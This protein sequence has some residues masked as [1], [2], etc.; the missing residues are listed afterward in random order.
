MI[1]CALGLSLE[2]DNI[3][4][5]WIPGYQGLTVYPHGAGYF[6]YVIVYSHKYLLTIWPLSFTD[7]RHQVFSKV[8]NFHLVTGDSPGFDPKSLQSTAHA[9]NLQLQKAEDE[10]SQLKYT[11]LYKTVL[12]SVSFGGENNPS[13]VELVM[14]NLENN[15][16]IGE[17]NPFTIFC[18]CL[19]R[20]IAFWTSFLENVYQFW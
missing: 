11:E 15:A 18:Q 7:Q 1:V 10:P 9:K 20:P 3:H 13:S 17:S 6:M 5:E 8:C 16:T 14:L 4:G 2:E 12:P 19:S